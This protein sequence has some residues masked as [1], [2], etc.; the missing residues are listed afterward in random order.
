MLQGRSNSLDS[1]CVDVMR[2]LPSEGPK[3]TAF[4]TVVS[5]P[6]V[7]AESPFCNRKWLRVKGDADA[8]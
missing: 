3:P 4:R 5:L 8:Q 7:L 6:D 2:Y 1:W